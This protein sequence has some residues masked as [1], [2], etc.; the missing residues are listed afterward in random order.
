MLHLKNRA[1]LSTSQEFSPISGPRSSKFG[2]SLVVNVGISPV[3]WKK[4]S[5]VQQES[6]YRRW[7]WTLISQNQTC[8]HIADVEMTVSAK[9]TCAYSIRS[10]AYSIHYLWVSPSVRGILNMQWQSN[11][12]SSL[13]AKEL[14]QWWK[15]FERL[16]ITW[17]RITKMIA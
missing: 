3:V 15:F 4:R 17:V 9:K 2:T 5:Q 11:S 8:C 12:P 7:C 6:R 13:K 10:I 1:T 16:N 14:G